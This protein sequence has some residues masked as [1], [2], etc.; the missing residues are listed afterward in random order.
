M[1]FSEFLEQEIILKTY[2]T[3]H[4]SY[5]LNQGIRLVHEL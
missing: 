4:L 1:W 2:Y 5:Q 3:R